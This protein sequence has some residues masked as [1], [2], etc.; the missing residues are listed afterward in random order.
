MELILFF[1]FSDH[2][3]FE[4]ARIYMKSVFKLYHNQFNHHTSREFNHHTSREGSQGR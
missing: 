3:M 2:D 4:Q 1:F